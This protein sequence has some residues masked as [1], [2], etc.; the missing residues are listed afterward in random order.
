[1]KLI[2]LRLALHAVILAVTFVTAGRAED[3]GT[4]TY[5]NKELQAKIVYCKTCHGLSGQGFR[6]A[7]PMPRL[8]GQQPEYIEN[9][10]NAFIEKR[11][12][13]PI[14]ANVA[15]ALN[16]A[17]I[18]ALAA[19]FGELN[20]KPLGGAPGTPKE[21]VAVGK[22]IYEEGIP[23]SNIPPCASC[24]GPEAKGNGPFPRLAGQLNDYIFRKL[25]NWSKERGQNPAAP[26]TSAIM[27]PIA[28]NL[29]E[30]QITAVAGYLSYLD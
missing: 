4:A 14:M 5:S 10:L 29:T 22:K 1:M 16:P 2:S 19:H 23:E 25:V 11:R 7:F 21:L 8:A 18:Q 12:I 9:Q 24:H 28:H 20:P 27:E 6:G 15:H 30:S 26:D 13:N 17:M 3:E